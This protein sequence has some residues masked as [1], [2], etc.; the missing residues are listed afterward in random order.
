[1]AQWTRDERRGDPPLLFLGEV[2]AGTARAAALEERAGGHVLYSSRAAVAGGGT[3]YAVS[4][5]LE[6]SFFAPDFKSG[7]W[8]ISH[9]M[10]FW[11]VED[12]I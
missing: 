9:G 8:L 7:L 12:Q 6:T 1:M 2:G 4:S 3:W 5:V 10:Y 11:T